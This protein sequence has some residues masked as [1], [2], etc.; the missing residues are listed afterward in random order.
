MSFRCLLQKNLIRVALGGPI[1]ELVQTTGFAVH[2]CRARW[3]PAHP[4][5]KP[6]PP[7]PQLLQPQHPS[8]SLPLRYP[9]PPCGR[10]PGR[11]PP[12]E[13]QSSLSR[14]QG[15]SVPRFRPLRPTPAT[16][17]KRRRQQR[18]LRRRRRRRRTPRIPSPP[19]Q[20][21]RLWRRPQSTP[22]RPTDLFPLPPLRPHDLFPLL[23]PPSP[24]RGRTRLRLVYRRR[25][26]HP[27]TTFPSRVARSPKQQV[28]SHANMHS[29]TYKYGKGRMHWKSVNPLH[30]NINPEGFVCLCSFAHECTY[31]CRK[32][33]DWSTAASQAHQVTAH[34]ISVL[35]SAEKLML[36]M[37]KP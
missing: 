21:L 17:L 9:P 32:Q 25:Q 15:S 27:K 29:R 33:P 34:H 11:R 26:P 3:W 24:W 10:A 6:L 30:P 8:P 16:R 22:P 31:G 19:L 2:Y 23:Q 28:D 7:A 35:L 36:R 14:P 5:L 1:F 37:R 18:Q 4:L 20:L 13:D 12:R